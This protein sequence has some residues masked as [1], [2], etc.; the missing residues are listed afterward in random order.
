[1]TYHAREG[2][3]CFSEALAAL[4]R[5]DQ[6]RRKDWGTVYVAMVDDPLTMGKRLMKQ[7]AGGLFGADWLPSL[8][9]LLAE[10]W[11]DAVLPWDVKA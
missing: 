11:E 5:G 4:K 6:V 2:T 7:H 8:E 1:M 3:T 9:D 10:D